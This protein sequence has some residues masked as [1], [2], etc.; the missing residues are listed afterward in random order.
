MIGKNKPVTCIEEAQVSQHH[1]QAGEQ[2]DRGKIAHQQ[3]EVE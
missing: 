2:G 1:E 3:N